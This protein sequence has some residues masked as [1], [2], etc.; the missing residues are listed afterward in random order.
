MARAPYYIFN[1]HTHINL[2]S[3]T[4]AHP[5]KKV[6]ISLYYKKISPLPPPPCQE[7]RGRGEGGGV[8]ESPQFILF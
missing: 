7:S 3:Y 1:Y 5:G 6:Y 8:E 4:D 2:L